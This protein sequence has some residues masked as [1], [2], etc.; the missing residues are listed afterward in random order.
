M[1]KYP[2]N[3]IIVLLATG[4]VLRAFFYYHPPV[5]TLKVGDAAPAFAITLTD[6]KTLKS[7]D[8]KGKPLV[9]FFYANWCP[10]SHNSAPLVQKAYVENMKADVKFLSVGIQDG[11]SDLKDFVKRHQFTFY[12]G[13][14]TAG[15]VSDVF[16]VITTPTTIIVDKNWKISGLIVGQVKTFQA[17]EEKISEAVYDRV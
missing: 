6:G 17:I 1:K 16:G 14:D 2:V 15:K 9:L 11:E 5:N 10:C 13:V 12:T 3:K 7:E 8:L 4:L